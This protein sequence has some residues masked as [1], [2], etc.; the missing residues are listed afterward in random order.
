MSALEETVEVLNIHYRQF[1]EI[2]QA[3]ESTGHQVPSDTKAFSQIIVSKLVGIRGRDRKKGSDLED[4][5][6]VKAANLWNAIDTPRFNG[7]LPVG[8]TSNTAKRPDNSSALD[9]TPYIFFVLW[10]NVDGTGPHRIRI[11]VVRASKDD[12]FKRMADIWYER[13]R[14]GAIKSDNFQLHPPRNID[15]NV[16]RNEA[17][18]LIYPLLLD[19]RVR[20]AQYEVSKYDPTVLT[21]G[22]CQESDE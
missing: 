16:F 21:K 10:D 7:V 2:E 19:A 12:V 18:N 15:S 20:G 22:S 17:G 4:G 11:W 8:R 13:R 3:A 6:D 5:S 14:T 1:F 9:E